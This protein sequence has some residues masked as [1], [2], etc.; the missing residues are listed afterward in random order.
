MIRV[1]ATRPV[2]VPRLTTPRLVLRE[3]S[4]NDVDDLYLLRSNPEINRYIQRPETNSTE[5]ARNF[6]YLVKSETQTGR[7]VYWVIN[8]KNSE[9]VIGSICLW[10]VDPDCKKAEIGYELVPDHQG[11]G[12][13][14]EALERVLSFGF[15]EL[16]LVKIEAYTH[17]NNHSSQELLK[18]KGFEHLSEQTDPEFP[19][20]VVFGIT[21]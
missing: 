6:I 5:D 4:L 21:N 7:S 9:R 15:E 10:D 12:L 14:S 8:L 17:R 19:D 18:K 1:T 11:K 16:G 13:M 3:V 20:N 2:R